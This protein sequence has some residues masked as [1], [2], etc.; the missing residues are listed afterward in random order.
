MKYN[1]DSKIRDKHQLLHVSV[2]ECHLQEFSEHKE[3]EVQQSTSGINLDY[4]LYILYVIDIN[5]GSYCRVLNL[6]NS[7]MVLVF[8]FKPCTLCSLKMA[9][10]HRNR[11]ELCL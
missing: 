8:G 4:G 3:S 2:S 5:K 7:S 9:H 6:V 1:S 11:S 10:F